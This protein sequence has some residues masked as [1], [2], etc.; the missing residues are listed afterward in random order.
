MN[1]V[2]LAILSMFSAFALGGVVG[3]LIGRLTR[4]E[5]GLGVGLLM[6][7]L[8][9][10]GFAGQCLYDY[11]AFTQADA[12]GTHGEVVALRDRPANASGNTGRTVLMVRFNASD[13]REYLL[14]VPT[15]AGYADGDILSVIYDPNDPESA[16]FGSRSELRGG[17]IAMMLFG[18]FPSSVGLWFLYTY[19]FRIEAR[20]AGQSSVRS[21]GR[22]SGEWGSAVQALCIVVM[23]CGILWIG[24]G[25]GPLIQRFLDGFGVLAFA[26]ASLALWSALYSRTNA[27]W[28]LGLMVISINF[29]VWACALH[30][31]K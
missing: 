11:R 10:L 14:D 17:A 27:S 1:L 31:L 29:G 24:V 15:S 8:V 3:V 19:G 12:R 30:L 9:C 23:F 26:S 5:V 18:T 13:K 22:R 4:F 25:A 20:H 21:P 16:R 28:C 7:G 6:P 2:T